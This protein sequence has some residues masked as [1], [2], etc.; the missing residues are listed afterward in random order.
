MSPRYRTVLIVVSSFIGGVLITIGFA[1]L[2]AR[3]VIDFFAFAPID[4]AASE[5]EQHLHMLQ[6][7]R[8]GDTTRPIQTLEALVDGD[9]IT[10]G[11][12]Q[13]L[14]RDKYLLKRVRDA[15]TEIREYRRQFPTTMC[16]Q[17]VREAIETALGISSAPSNDRSCL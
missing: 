6:H 14:T 1:Y 9:T 3:P 8:Q 16:D 15:L 12:Y 7:L 2:A 5:G 17:Q 10:L 13:E 11:S 4:R